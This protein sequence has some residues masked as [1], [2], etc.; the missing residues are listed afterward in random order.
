M[1]TAF[2]KFDSYMPPF[3]SVGRHPLGSTRNKKYSAARCLRALSI[4]G[5]IQR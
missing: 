3:Q 4:A 1:R 2:H 5:N